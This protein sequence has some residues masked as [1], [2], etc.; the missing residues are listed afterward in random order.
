MKEIWLSLLIMVA[1]ALTGCKED[2]RGEYMDWKDRYLMEICSQ[3]FD[4]PGD[5]ITSEY[6]KDGRPADHKG[7]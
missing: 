7:I 1:V 5:E 3:A 2:Q 6:R 4:K